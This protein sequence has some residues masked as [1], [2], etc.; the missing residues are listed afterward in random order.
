MLSEIQRALAELQEQFPFEDAYLFGSIVKPGRYREDSDIDIAIRGLKPEHFFPALA[1][2]M[3]RLDRD[4]DL[5][6][7]ET[8]RYRERIL[9][10]AIKWTKP[11][12]S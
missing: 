6:D 12:S 3:R 8:S 7:L 5:I 4:V 1:W 2:L 11:N 10:E 9:Q